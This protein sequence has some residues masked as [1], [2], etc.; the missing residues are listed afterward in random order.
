MSTTSYLQQFS[1]AINE[2]ALEKA[3]DITKIWIDEAPE[4]MAY[5]CAGMINRKMGRL[6]AAQEMVDFGKKHYNSVFI[7]QEQALIYMEQGKGP[8]AR[9]TFET[10]IRTNR[11]FLSAWQQLW[12]LTKDQP[13]LFLPQEV[14]G[15]ERQLRQFSDMPKALVQAYFELGNGNVESANT[16]ITG[17]FNQPPSDHRSLSG[18]VELAQK[19]N[20]TRF[21]IRSLEVALQKAEQPAWLFEV[22]KLLQNQQNFYQAQKYLDALSKYW[23]DEPLFK[24]TQASQLLHTN[25]VEEAINVLQMLS[26]NND[27]QPLQARIYIL[28]GQCYQTLQN[29]AQSADFFR[30]TLQFEHVKGEA[31]WHLANLKVARFSA[32]EKRDI[33]ALAQSNNTAMDRCYAF[34]ALGMAQNQDGEFAKAFASFTAANALKRQLNPYDVN[35]ITD[36]LDMLRKA[37][38]PALTKTDAATTSITPV[39]IV[40]LPR[41]GSTL[42]DQ[43]LAAHPHI[44]GTKELTTIL[45]IVQDMAEKYGKAFHEV[46]PNLTAQEKQTY[47]NWYLESAATFTKNSAYFIDKNP[48][49]FKYI[50]VILA[51]FP[52]AKIIDLRRDPVANGLSAYRH[53]FASGHNYSNALSDFAQYYTAY[54]KVISHFA[55]AYPEAV[56]TITYE[57]LVNEPVPTLQNVCAF[58]G[59]EEIAKPLDF[60]KHQRAIHTPSVAQVS[61]PLD[62][63]KVNEWQDFAEFLAPLLALQSELA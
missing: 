31:Y 10:I 20:M 49:N 21:V 7:L 33:D 1:Q 5:A 43:M 45:H 57:T 55:A 4:T 23:S 34:Y 15:V 13:S 17:A 41:S 61:Q 22:V 38:V 47:A 30:L 59:V 48:E 62:P 18:W 36:S 40:G 53:H 52:Q 2:K 3:V 35:T 32:D 44:D 14:A 19:Q 56:T 26:A 42:L 50:S 54:T 28:L 51:L 60:Y 12:K 29:I 25:R 8:E 63:N 9:D 27:N 46:L 37:P 24:L 16:L 58:I 39:F 6:E 11:Y